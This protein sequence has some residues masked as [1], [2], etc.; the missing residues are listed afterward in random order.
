MANDRQR[1]KWDDEN[2]DDR[3]SEFVTTTFS[4]T[5]GALHS[6]WSRERRKR[7]RAAR[8]AG[9]MWAVLAAVGAST[10]LLYAVA[11]WLR[12]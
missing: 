4:T 6:S 2:K 3:P 8:R 9:V 5:A 11:S 10:L 7:R 12:H 1:Y